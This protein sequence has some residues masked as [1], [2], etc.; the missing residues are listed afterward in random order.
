MAYNGSGTYVRV[1]N[2]QADA[3]AHVKIK[4]D[5]H[6]TQDDDFA[7]ALSNVVCKDGQSSPVNDLPMNG[8]KLTGLSQPVAPNDSAT[9][10]Y[11]DNVK[12]FALG[13][14]ISGADANGQLNFSATTGANGLTFTGADLSWL[15]RLATAAGPGT[16]PNPPATLNR[17]VASSM[18]S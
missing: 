18:R 16:P 13:M 17:P 10:A 9:K 15:A 12:T 4:S 8:H 2:W 6:D 7:V 5:R 3:T 11:V 1:T 14:T